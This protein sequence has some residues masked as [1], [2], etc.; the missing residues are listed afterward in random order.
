MDSYTAAVIAAGSQGRVHARGY[1][2]DARAR[3]LAVA[4]INRAAAQELAD[5]LSIPAVYE[6]YR[7]LLETQRPELVSVCTPPAQHLD[8]VR[9][10][11]AAGARAIHCE[12]PV[13]LSY[14]DALEMARVTRD[15]G[16][17]LTVNLQRRFE[18]VHRFAREQIVGGVLG[19]VVSIEGYCPNL[20][21]W[22]AHVIDLMFFYLGDA[23]A[24]SVIGQVDVSVN[25]YVY[26]AFAE[27]A[28]LT[29]V[30]WANGISAIIATGREPWTPSLNLQNNLGILVQGTGGRLDARGARCV[31]R[32]FGAEDVVLESPFDRDATHWERGVD[33]A[34]VAGTAEAISDAITSLGAGTEPV[35]AAAH[36]LAGA[37]VIFATYESSRSRRR[38]ELPL[39]QLDNALT[40]G[41]RT[42]FWHP[43]GELR[44]TY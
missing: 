13:A 43:V 18:A 15:A 34:I 29:Q 42:G 5:D 30:R 37:E 9:A 4:D 7:E 17:Q 22:G 2:A 23:P 27:T 25:R 16:V 36:A 32:R 28:S 31:V 38:I 41:L 40:A 12:K 39:R 19:D 44:S 8:V 10:A 21:D 6:D 20:G 11:V 3:L 14:G 1:A 26:G 35:C 24:Q 33:P